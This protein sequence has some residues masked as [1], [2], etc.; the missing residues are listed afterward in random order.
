M[1]FTEDKRKPS[2][3]TENCE[4]QL[5]EAIK[6]MEKNSPQ[7]AEIMR[8]Q[9]FKA[10]RLLEAMPWIGTKYKNG[11][12]KMKLGKFRYNIFYIEQDSFISIRGIWHTSRGADFED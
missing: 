10:I 4:M 2:I 3:I 11:M 5:D 8:S 1:D 12:R 6:Y 7:Q 9:F